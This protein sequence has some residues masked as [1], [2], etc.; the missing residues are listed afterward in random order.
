MNT[1]VDT[2]NSSLIFCPNMA[3][4]DHSCLWHNSEQN[5]KSGTGVFS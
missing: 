4:W 1:V 5:H 2:D 3:L